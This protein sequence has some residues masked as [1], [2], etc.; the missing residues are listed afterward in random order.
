MYHTPNSYSLITLG[1]PKTRP[2]T[3]DGS[4]PSDLR[5]P[6]ALRD[7]LGRLGPGTSDHTADGSHSKMEWLAPERVISPPRQ[8]VTELPRLSSKERTAE[9]EKSQM[10]LKT[11]PSN[12]T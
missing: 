9:Y 1:G 4:S 6:G 7:P 8:I 3:S 11:L 5:R 2:S 12:S 10:V